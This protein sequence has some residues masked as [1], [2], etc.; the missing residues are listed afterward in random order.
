MSALFSFII[1]LFTLGVDTFSTTLCPHIA[2]KHKWVT[3]SLS[4]EV[5]GGKSSTCNPLSS[6]GGVKAVIQNSYT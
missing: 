2:H 3:P 4:S 5:C 6:D 1:I